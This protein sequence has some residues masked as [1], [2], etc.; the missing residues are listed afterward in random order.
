[1][2]TKWGN[3]KI[4]ND[5]YYYITT[6]ENNGKLLHRLIYEDE[7]GPIPQGFVVHHLDGNKQNNEINNLVLLSISEHHSMHATKE[8]HPRWGT[9]IVDQH[10]GLDFIVNQKS[11]NKTMTGIAEEIGYTSPVPIHQYLK[12]RNLSWNKI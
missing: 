11:K 1:M 12:N 8:N 2:K 6:K 10:G 9:S 5:G 7:F 3:A 4:R